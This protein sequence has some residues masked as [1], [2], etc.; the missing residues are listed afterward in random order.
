M[1][2]PR[3][4]REQKM[5]RQ[6]CRQMCFVVRKCKYQLTALKCFHFLKYFQTEKTSRANSST[7]SLGRELVLLCTHT[8]KKSA[9]DHLWLNHYNVIIILLTECLG[10]MHCWVFGGQL[11]MLV[12]CGQT[13]R[14]FNNMSGISTLR[15]LKGNIFL[16]KL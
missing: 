11:Q 7:D 1:F 5:Q 16:K 10:N 9:T 8:Q 12:R 13:T 15:A 2:L 4:R 14:H 6:L 3:H